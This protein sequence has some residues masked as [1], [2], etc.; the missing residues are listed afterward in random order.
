MIGRRLAHY[1]ITHHLGS[2]AMGDVYQATDSKLG[3]SVAIKLLP[4]AFTHD[5]ER[6]ARFQREA[7]VLASLN[8]PNIATIHGLEES[9]DRK[10]LVMEL[11]PGETLA[12][13]MARGPIGVVEALQIAKQIAEPLEY[14]HGKGVIHRDIKPANVK[15]TP[16]GRVKVLD[17]GLAKAFEAQRAV[18]DPSELP[19]LMA[20]PTIEGQIVGTPAYMSPERVRGQ[21][22]DRQA[23]VWSFGCLLFE[24]LTG[25][26]AFG[27]KTLS[28]TIAKVLEREPD[29]QALPPPTPPKVRD[30][31]RRCLDKDVNR[32][33]PDMGSARLQIQEAL[34]AP[35][36]RLSRRQLA[37]TVGVMLVTLLSLTLG[38]NMGGLR[39]RLRGTDT[40]APRIQ[41]LA[42]LPLRNLSGD[43]A[44]EYFADGM[45]E[46]LIAQLSK[47]RTLKLISRTSAM[48]YKNTDKTMPVIARELGVDG[49]V[50]GAVLREGDQVRITLQLLDGAADQTLWAESYQREMRGVLSLTAEIARAVAREIKITLTPQE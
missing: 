37:A 2:G 24:L 35:G 46:E 32:R 15:V 44:E 13:R 36:W 45:T 4:E 20:A 31:L 43:P 3:R 41:S 33:L 34:A 29:W 27:G 19:T 18:A 50:E 14:A 48:R 8:H 12:D 23:D 49:V 26:R 38:L 6:V 25:Q 40:L 47:I 1:E 10:F 11:V 42:V 21:P 16:E 5:A 9:G 22:L 17:F 30:L 28:D 7:R 39:S